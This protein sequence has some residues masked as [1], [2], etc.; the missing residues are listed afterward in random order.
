[1]FVGLL[2]LELRLHGVDSL[3]GKRAIVKPILERTR[4]KFHCAAAETGDNDNHHLAQIGIS[5]V[6]NDQSFLNGCLDNIANYIE[7]LN[8]AEVIDQEW[9]ILSFP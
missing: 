1:M 4:R 9:E 6:G 8:L 5:V 7:S 2:R 3:K